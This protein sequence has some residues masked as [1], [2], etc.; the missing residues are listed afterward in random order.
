VLGFANIDAG[1]IVMISANPS[2]VL[3]L[4]FDIE[5]PPAW[6]STNSARVPSV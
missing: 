3:R 2:N 4:G 6:K 5:L 1:R